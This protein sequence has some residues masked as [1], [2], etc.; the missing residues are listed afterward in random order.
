MT[1]WH[2]SRVGQ[3]ATG[4]SSATSIGDEQAPAEQLTDVAQ[5]GVGGAVGDFGVLR[6]GQVAFKAVQQAV[7]HF[8]WRAWRGKMWHPYASRKQYRKQGGI[9][10]GAG[11]GAE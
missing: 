1:G 4:A 8:C 5:G 2:P 11:S 10:I 3:S 7:E 9:H 6:V